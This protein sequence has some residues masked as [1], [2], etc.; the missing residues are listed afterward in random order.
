MKGQEQKLYVH[1][2]L[3]GGTRK[4]WCLL[5][6]RRTNPKRLLVIVVDV[7]HKSTRTLAT[8]S[9]ILREDGRQGVYEVIHIVKKIYKRYNQRGP[10]KKKEQT[11][12]LTYSQG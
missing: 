3:L 7:S 12:R 8:C 11:Y 4:F 9:V 5:R 2:D 1:S 6:L 10:S